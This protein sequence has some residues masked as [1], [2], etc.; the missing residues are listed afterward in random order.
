M[1]SRTLTVMV[2]DLAISPRL[3]VHLWW[4]PSGAR[5]DPGRRRANMKP[6]ADGR[7]ST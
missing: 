1:R 2:R 5:G 4:S 7:R 3:A 6:D